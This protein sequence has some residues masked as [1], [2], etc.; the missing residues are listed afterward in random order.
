M[1]LVGLEKYRSALVKFELKT[2]CLGS[3]KS[4]VTSGFTGDTNSRVKVVCMTHS[5]SPTYT[6]LRTLQITLCCSVAFDHVILTQMCLHRRYNVS[7]QTQRV[8]SGKNLKQTEPI[9]MSTGVQH[10]CLT[11]MLAWLQT[12]SLT[13]QRHKYCLNAGWKHK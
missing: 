6:P 3:G 5:S 4:L 13:I 2:T 11:G 8:T 7:I 1:T 12:C 10:Y 9:N